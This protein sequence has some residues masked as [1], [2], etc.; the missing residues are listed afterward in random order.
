M[1]SSIHQIW[2]QVTLLKSKYHSFIVDSHPSIPITILEN[3]N[4]HKNHKQL[5]ISYDYYY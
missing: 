4:Q 1:K 3:L 5:V 2:H